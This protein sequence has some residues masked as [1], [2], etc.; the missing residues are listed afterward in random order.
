MSSPE[1]LDLGELGAGVNEPA[2][3][4]PPPPSSPAKKTTAKKT[5]AKKTAGTRKDAKPR[6]PGRPTNDQKLTEKLVEF[7]SVIG[8]ALALVN[9]DDA[10]VVLDNAERC[11]ESLVRLS[12]EYPA[13]RRVLER[14][15]EGG[16]IFGVLIAHGGVLY[17]IAA[18]HNVVPALDFAGVGPIG[19]LGPDAGGLPFDLSK[20]SPEDMTAIQDLG[21]KLTGNGNGGA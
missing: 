2:T 20:L 8:A 19:D 12:N 16:A 13:V 7:Y 1:S 17:K 5:T 10:L 18:N 4:P 14:G 21:A 15:A 3:P 6:Q 9:T 11:A